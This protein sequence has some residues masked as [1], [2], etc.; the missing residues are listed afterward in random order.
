MRSLQAAVDRSLDAAVANG[1][2]EVL[3][4]PPEAVAVDLDTYCP[5]QGIEGA[6]PH[7]LAPLVRS[8]QERH[9]SEA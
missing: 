2:D 9:A 3:T 1:Y 4:D 8:W 6:E 5:E 7:V